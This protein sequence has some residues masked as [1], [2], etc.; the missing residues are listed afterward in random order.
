VI[1]FFNYLSHGPIKGSQESVDSDEINIL[2]IRS[3]SQLAISTLLV[4]RVLEIL[5]FSR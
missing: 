3:S 5:V 4:P 1:V 2:S